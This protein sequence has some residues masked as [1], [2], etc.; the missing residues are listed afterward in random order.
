MKALGH[1]LIFLYDTHRQIESFLSLMRSFVEECIKVGYKSLFI[2]VIIST[3]TGAVSV[4]QTAFNL[5]SPWIQDY[6]VAM[7]VRDSTFSLIPTLIALVYAG[8]VGSHMSSELGTMQI[9]EQIDALE[10]MGI[11]S[12]SFLV[13]PKILASLVMF[14]ML[15]II[16]CF[17][18]IYGGYVASTLGSII[19]EQDYITGIRADFNDFII[20]IILVKSLV[21][22][23]MIP[24]IS[25]YE[26]YHTSGGALEV[27]KSSTRAVIKC[28]ISVLAADFILTQLMAGG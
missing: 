14:P 25:S 17:M 1:F 8:K 24:A 7:V 6:I 18:S 3:F 28:C 9:S 11:N 21:Y 5:T 12:K 15:I 16:G 23:I 22:S 2:V 19:S 4:I 20:T 27:G 13:L 10:V 26:G